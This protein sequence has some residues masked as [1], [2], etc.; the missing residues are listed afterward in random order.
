MVLVSGLVPYKTL[1]Q[2]ATDII[3]KCNSYFIRKC[4][5]SLLQN[6]S[7]C[8]LQT[9]TVLLKISTVNATVLTNWEV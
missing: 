3:T 6:V 1:L 4:D 2:N 9:A 8:L 5:K 7:G